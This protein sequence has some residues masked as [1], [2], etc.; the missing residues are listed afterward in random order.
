MW[1]S[2]NGTFLAL[3]QVYLKLLGSHAT[4]PKPKT[5]LYSL[6]FTSADNTWTQAHSRQ[7]R[8]AILPS[9]EMARTAMGKDTLRSAAREMGSKKLMA[10]YI[11]DWIIIIAFAG[12][13]GAL[14]FVHPKHRPFSLLNTDISFPYVDESITTWMLVVIAFLAPAVLILLITLIFVPG[15]EIRRISTRSQVLRLKLWELEKGLAG[16]CLSVAVA[17]FISM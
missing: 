5:F 17:F 2:S 9:H 11:F 8:I 1:L 10:S 12:A 3:S 6:D 4:L 7:A 16:L 14:S 15:R 13:G